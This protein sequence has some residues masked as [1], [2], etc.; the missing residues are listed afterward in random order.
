[1]GI[2]QL[3]Q[4]LLTDLGNLTGDVSVP[5]DADVV[6]EMKMGVGRGALQVE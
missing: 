1:M 6:A 2:L 3:V 4:W 5:I